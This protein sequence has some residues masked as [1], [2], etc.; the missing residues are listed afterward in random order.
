MITP[1]AFDSIDWKTYVIFAVMYV[2]FK[3]TSFARW[4]RYPVL[5]ANCSFFFRNAVIFPV[6]YFFYPET[7]YRSL[8]EMDD[9]FKKSNNVFDV[10]SISI[11]EPHRYDKFGQLKPEYIEDVQ[12]QRSVKSAHDLKVEHSEGSSS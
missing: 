7:R 11:N 1:V 9:I 12:R 2:Y 3:K 4:H 5:L 6:V 10:V 8:E